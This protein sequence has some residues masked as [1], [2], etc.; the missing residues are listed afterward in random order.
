MYARG[1]AKLK[2]TSSDSFRTKVGATQELVRKLPSCLID[3]RQADPQ[4][5]AVRVSALCFN[6][7]ISFIFFQ[8]SSCAMVILQAV[9]VEHR[10]A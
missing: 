9:K 10:S 8:A 7:A 4:L 3:S 6:L 2:V 1:I 5:C